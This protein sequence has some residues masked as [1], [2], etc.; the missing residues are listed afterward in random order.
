MNVLY[1]RLNYGNWTPIQFADDPEMV[2]QR[3]S[4]IIV[5]VINSIAAAIFI[6]YMVMPNQDKS[7]KT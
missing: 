6:A 3:P 5:Y 2:R 1:D 7:N 4:V